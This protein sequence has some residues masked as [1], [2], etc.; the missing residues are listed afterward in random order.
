VVDRLADVVLPLVDHLVDQ[1]GVAGHRVGRCRLDER[2]AVAVAPALDRGVASRQSLRDAE[3]RSRQL[4][5]E[6]P[7][8]ERLPA[9]QQS[10]TVADRLQVDADRRR[11]LKMT[12]D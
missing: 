10:A 4:A 6:V 1:D 12:S 9:C 3:R 8:V 11:T 5:A 2:D 7:S